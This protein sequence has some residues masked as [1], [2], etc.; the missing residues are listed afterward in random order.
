M[1]TLEHE[2]TSNVALTAA[3]QRTLN[4]DARGWSRQPHHDTYMR[5]PWGRRKRWDYWSIQ[6][7]DLIVSGVVANIDYL[8]TSDIW[9]R[10]LS[11]GREGGRE[12]TK[13]LG[14][15]FDL[16]SRFGSRPVRVEAKNYSC[17]LADDDARNMHIHVE[18]TEKSGE[19]GELHA[20][21][22]M[23][24]GDES[25]NVVIPWS[26]RVFQY[27]SKHQA[28]PVTGSM[29]IGDRTWTFDREAWG[30]LDIGR[31]RWPFSTRWNWGG[32]SGFSRD[33]ARIG[34][35]IGGKWTDGTGFT[36]NGV[37]V[38][39]KLSKIGRELNWTYDWDDTMKPWR[40]VDTDGQIDIVMTPRYDKHTKLD[41][42]VLMRETHQVFGTWTGFVVDDA[43]RRHDVDGIQGFAEECRARW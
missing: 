26:D 15:G 32:G 31:G 21:I 4:P 10:D 39:G 5:G 24:A 30:I 12:V 22:T 23:P 7:G 25:L 18:W 41:L 36:E 20:V 11:S 2:I 43:G 17:E 29:R 33:G 6:A 3:N 42:K 16:P 1:T 37:F 8:S 19:V 34:I 38:D 14:K 9:W 27:T 28:R 13:F 35:Q 40:V